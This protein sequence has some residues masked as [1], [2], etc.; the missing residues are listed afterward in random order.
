MAK[1]SGDSVIV[2]KG[3]TLSQIAIDYGNGKTYLQLA[4][5]NGIKNPDRIYVGQVI[6]LNKSG[7]TSPTPTLQPKAVTIK[8]F[9]L[10]SDTDNTLFVVWEWTRR[11]ATENYKVVWQYYTADKHWFTGSSTTTEE[12]EHLYNIPDNAKKVRVKI[13]PIPKKKTV[14]GKETDLFTSSWQQSKEYIANDAPGDMP[15]PTVTLELFKLTAEVTNISEDT[16]SIVEFELV[17]ND[18]SGDS[19]KAKA[20]VV[21]GA[22]SHTFTIL[23]G[24]RYKVRCRGI[25]NDIPGEWSDYSSNLNTAPEVP[26][27]ITKCIATSE[28]SIRIEWASVNNAT[29][30]DIEY[31][32]DKS[33]FDGSDQTTTVTG[34]EFNHYE[35][36]GLSSGDEYFFRVRAVNDKGHS[37]WSDISSATIGTGPAAPT[38]WSSTTTA[39]IGEA[40]H[41]YWIHN[42]EDN[43]AQTYA[44]IELNVN[45]EV[46]TKTVTNTSEDNTT[47]SYDLDTS[48]YPEGAKILWRVR[49]AGITKVYGEWSVQRT[50]DIYA[51]P[52]L[53]LKLTNASGGS[54]SSVVSS[55]PFYISASTGPATQKPIGYNLTIHADSSYETVD[56]TGSVRRV[57]AGEAVYSRYFDT[58]EDLLVEMTATSVDLDNSAE[59]TVHC[60]ASMD[61]GLTAED[62]TSFIV[63]LDEVEYEPNA[64]ITVD[65]E[66]FAAYIRP[67]CELHG[68]FIYA[69]T[70]N[71]G[72]YTKTDVRYDYVYGQPIEG[73]VTTTG[74]QV[75]QG[76][77]ENGEPVYYC[78]VEETNPVEDVTLSVY[79]REFDGSFTEIVT[80]IDGAS[81]TYVTDPHPSL[82]YARYR[83]V[84]TSKTTGA[85][86]Y[87]DPPGYPVGGKSVVIQWDEVWSNFETTN[88]DEMDQPSWSGSMLKLPYNIDVS[89]NSKKDVAL[90]E[91]IGRKRPVSYYGTQL[92]E[93]STWNVAIEKSDKET[94]YAL[95]RLALWTGDVYV[96]EPSGSGYWANISVSFSQT[97]T[98]LIIP[99]TLDIVRVEGG[100]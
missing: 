31:T 29:S 55:F 16:A 26:S 27:A 10:Q 85:I 69:V 58:N 96:R 44:E 43:S 89:D 65:P 4:A 12:L 79:R 90:I 28:T 67:Y 99:V 70:Y 46:E 100:V 91:Y 49:T 57:N 41:L 51:P 53:D 80:G 98:E 82:D 30:Y 39:I 76:I 18:L 45:G 73:A 81:N 62:Y 50:V 35:K 77:I 54:L 42:T 1:L 48:S 9:G 94:L 68:L 75:Y 59:Y 21:T 88:E 36:T 17:K 47:S 40:L 86:G 25:K 13:R 84:S 95:R 22:A 24:S 32:T 38:T 8:Q 71:S 72:V 93:S 2:E 7:S 3:D 78:Q 14:N 37:G 33:Y 92:G 56:S 61:S 11:S 63:T 23:A 64:E 34:I 60:T 74:E 15:V 97:H 66:T 6:K 20:K 83:I 5:I 52:V 19:K 87:F